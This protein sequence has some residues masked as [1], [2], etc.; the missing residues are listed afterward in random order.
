[1][2]LVLHKKV[3]SVP[4]LGKTII[5]DFWTPSALTHTAMAEAI[6]LPQSFSLVSTYS[7]AMD[8]ASGP[9]WLPN[10]G[11]ALTKGDTSR[12]IP[13]GLVQCVTPGHTFLYF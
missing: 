2:F 3:G 11:V 6:Y 1:M 5:S 12:V 7:P 13:L 4:T 9:M 10:Y 8:V